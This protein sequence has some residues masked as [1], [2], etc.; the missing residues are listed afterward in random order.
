[1]NEYNNPS[2]IHCYMRNRMHSPNIKILHNYN[3]KSE[4]LGFWT[5]SIVRNSKYYKT[6]HFGNWICLRPQ[7]KG[8]DT[9]SV[10]SLRKS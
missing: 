8:R 2:F 3:L 10:G 4:L 1:M 7:V 5:L 6:Q 9:Y